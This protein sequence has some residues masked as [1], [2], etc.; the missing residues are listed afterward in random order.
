MV[1][2][3]V[4]SD[5][6]GGDRRNG[7]ASR[8]ARILEAIFGRKEPTVGGGSTGEGALLAPGEGGER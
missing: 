1:G 5:L 2:V 3:K 6:Q 4:H 7:L 8:R